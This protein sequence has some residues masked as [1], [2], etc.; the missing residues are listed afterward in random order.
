[1]AGGRAIASMAVT[2]GTISP[3]SMSGRKIRTPATDRNPMVVMTIPVGNEDPDV[4]KV[5]RKPRLLPQWFTPLAVAGL[6][7]GLGLFASSQ[8][9]PFLIFNA[10]ASAPIGLYRLLPPGPIE[11]GE[12]LLVRTPQTVR[13]LA[14]ERNYIPS[15]VPLVKR[16]AALTGDTVCAAGPTLTIN[17]RWVAD[18][19]SFDREGRPLPAWTGCRKLAPDEI[20][21]LMVDVPDSFDSRYFGPVSADAIIG[22]LTPLWLR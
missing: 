2:S 20:F 22:R 7:V 8:R 16:V 15:S 17:D 12:L 11:Y 21:L 3:I 4:T 19:L 5:D 1:M 9:S 18:R 13:A 14:A 10:S 6:A